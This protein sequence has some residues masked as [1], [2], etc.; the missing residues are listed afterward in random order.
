MI[1][2]IHEELIIIPVVSELIEV[3]LLLHAKRELLVDWRVDWSLPKKLLI[4]ITSVFSALDLRF[5][6]SLHL[7]L[8]QGVPVQACEKQ[9]FL[10]ILSIC[11]G[12]PQSL[13]G[14]GVQQ[15]PQEVVQ[16]GG[17]LPCLDWLVI[18]FSS[19]YSIK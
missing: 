19:C 2:L 7:Q 6:G 17:G 8:G 13:Q 11:L 10:N 5:E 3:S 15:F 4:N 18:Y 16:G 9:V 12:T 1:I 14:I